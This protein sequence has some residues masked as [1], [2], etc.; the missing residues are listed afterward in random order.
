MS[1]LLLTASIISISIF[2]AIPTVAA[3][4]ATATLLCFNSNISWQAQINAYQHAV[5]LMN[6]VAT[7]N[8]SLTHF[9]LAFEPSVIVPEPSPTL[10]TALLVGG[11]AI[12][13]AWK[14]QRKKMPDVEFARKKLISSAIYHTFLL[15]CSSDKAFTS[16][17]TNV[18]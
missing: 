12:G 11:T 1:K 15:P 8:T 10:A 14:K 5:L 7:L 2:L 18:T 17:T 16:D 9:D 4:E 13:I 6:T 3:P